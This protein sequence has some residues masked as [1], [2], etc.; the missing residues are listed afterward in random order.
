M[1]VLEFEKAEPSQRC[2]WHALQSDEADSEVR[3]FSF[4]ETRL[5][6]RATPGY[7]VRVL[8]RLT[9]FRYGPVLDI[10]ALPSMLG[11]QKGTLP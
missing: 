8:A 10:I 11:I 2:H 4:V 9:L 5:C 6:V 7:N 1:R 3:S